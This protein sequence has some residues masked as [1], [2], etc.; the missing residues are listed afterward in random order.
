VLGVVTVS[1][2]EA[3]SA[4][5]ARGT[6]SAVCAASAGEQEAM[7]GIVAVPAHDALS[8]LWSGRAGSSIRAS[9]PGKEKSMLGIVA[10]LA[11]HP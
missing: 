1:A 9:R 5:H 3:L 8:A 7:F 11:R 10:G 6:G 4:L 2:H